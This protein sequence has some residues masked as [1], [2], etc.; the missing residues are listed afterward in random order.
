MKDNIVLII[1]TA[2]AVFIRIFLIVRDSF[3][4]AY[5]M[6]RDLLWAKDISFY[7]TPTLIGPAASI[8]GVYFQPFWYYFLA[9]PIRLFSPHP[10]SAV[11]VTAGAV[12]LTGVLAIVLFR[13][14]LNPLYA[15]V[16]GILLFFSNTLVNISTFAFHANLLPLLT[17]LTTYFLFLSAVKNPKYF[18]LAALAI[19]FMFS[20]DPAPAVTFTLIIL[21]MFFYLKIFKSTQATVLAITA[22][23]LP[24]IPQLLFELRNNF[25]ETRSLISY[26]AGNNPSLSG[27][28]PLLERIP[29]R[30][31]LYFASLKTDLAP[32]TLFAIALLALT[33]FG[34]YRFQKTNVDKN[35]S[36][37]F[38]INLFIIVLSFLVNTFLITVEIKNWYL[39]GMIVNFSI[40]IVFALLG[41]RSKLTT[42]IFL[43]LFLVVN[44]V[45][46][47]SNDKIVNAKNDPAQL[48]NQL[49][50]LDHIYTDGERPFSVYVYTPS[51]YDHNYQYLF[52]WWG[53]IRE[54]GLPSDFAYLP[55]QPD[56]VRNK[57]KY[58][59]LTKQAKTIYLIIE[60]ARQNE[61]YTD[62]AW[63][64]NFS[65]YK[66][67]WEKN[68]NGAIRL[69]KRVQ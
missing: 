22:S 61:F 62:I 44:L 67:V 2:L 53:T 8:W 56:Y 43:I 65:D 38:K 32:N 55:Q 12:V 49:A 52:W 57:S 9:L 11:L 47:A 50:A 27:Q 33:V 54:K 51:V 31:S 4:F 45:P 30:L 35:L 1:I 20:A 40:L 63:Q 26:F 25:I 6:G 41:L 60:N 48:S 3:P 5:D 16:F 18:A 28:L 19:A 13:K 23:V 21:C 36:I 39:F 34:I 29:N 14:Y 10:V 37:L 17:L 42:F 58:A 68:I 24:H 69:Q 66:I 7:Y 15:L 59:P 46:F 64:N